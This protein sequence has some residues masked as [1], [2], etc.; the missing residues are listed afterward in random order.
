MGP[1][2][3]HLQST[4]QNLPTATAFGQGKG[5][6]ECRSPPR[7]HE[8][9]HLSPASTKKPARHG[10]GAGRSEEKCLTDISSMSYPDVDHS[11]RAMRLFCSVHETMCWRPM[12]T[13]TSEPYL[14]WRSGSAG[15]SA[16]SRCDDAGARNS[17]RRV[18]SKGT[19]NGFASRPVPGG[20]DVGARRNPATSAAVNRPA[21]HGGR[22]RLSSRI[23][24]RLSR[25]WVVPRERLL[26]R[27]AI[28]GCGREPSSA[29]RQ[30]E[31]TPSLP[32]ALPSRI[33]FG[34]I[35]RRFGLC[36]CRPCRFDQGPAGIRDRYQPSHPTFHD[37]QRLARTA[38]VVKRGKQS[39]SRV[40]LQHLLAGSA[41]I[42]QNQHRF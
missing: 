23:T 1:P 9:S 34:K 18:A 12:P 3:P 27:S 31:V 20:R 37:R 21:G 25:S 33:R 14:R 15:P 26:A 2:K 29:K 17:Q 38:M 39:H 35:H 41:S 16:A 32:L 10:L 30:R 42:W 6:S 40:E 8:R 4:C 7:Q 11:S 13:V 19:L 24:I 5:V 28:H 22:H 36:P